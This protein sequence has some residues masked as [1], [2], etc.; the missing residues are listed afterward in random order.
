MRRAYEWWIPYPL[1]VASMVESAG[2]LVGE[3]DFSSFQA[4]DSEMTDPHRT[5]FSASL[6]RE[7][8]VI[9]LTIESN[10]FLKHMVRNIMGTLV[11]VGKGKI[12]ASSVKDVLESRDRTR[13]GPT[14]PAH[15]LCLMQ[16]R[17]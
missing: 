12:T 2:C 8:D 4:S 9:T 14:A 16:V 3:H 15:G 10:G 1:D 11:L 17:Y 5:V 6:G 7:G 13:A